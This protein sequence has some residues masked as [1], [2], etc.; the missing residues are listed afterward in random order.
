ME[1]R[2]LESQKLLEIIFGNWNGAE[3]KLNI[4]IT[5]KSYTCKK[6]NKNE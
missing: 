5:R 1:S 4:N 3:I 6:L 2:T